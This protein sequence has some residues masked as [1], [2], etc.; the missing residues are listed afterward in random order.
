MLKYARWNVINHARSKYHEV[1]E[2][3]KHFPNKK[4]FEIM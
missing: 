4:N 2:V 3:D 1:W